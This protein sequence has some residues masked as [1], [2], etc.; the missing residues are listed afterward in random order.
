MI[1]EK[2]FEQIVSKGTLVVTFLAEWCGSSKKMK[3]VLDDFC[4]EI[5]LRQNRSASQIWSE[6]RKA[7]G[8]FADRL[9]FLDLDADSYKELAFSHHIDRVPWQFLYRNGKCVAMRIGRTDKNGLKKFINGKYPN[10]D[11]IYIV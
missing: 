5:G 2:Q 8:A 10:T 6:L 11:S 1:S 9:H 7:D 4:A 3:E